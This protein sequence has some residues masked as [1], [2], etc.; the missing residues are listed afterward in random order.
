MTEHRRDS[1]NKEFE[2][3]RFDDSM[4]GKVAASWPVLV[5]T[6][7]LL[8]SLGINMATLWDHTSHL[9][10]IDQWHAEGQAARAQLS[11]AITQLTVLQETMDK[12]I[13]SVENWRNRVDEL[14][15]P[16]RRRE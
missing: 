14:T 13:T 8:V 2:H 3:Q 10:K 11:Q 16:H 7:T 9:S 5:G 6:C 4:L 12:R 15:P 1:E